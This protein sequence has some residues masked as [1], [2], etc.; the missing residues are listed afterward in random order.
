MRPTFSRCGSPEPFSMLMAWRIRTAAGGVLVT[1]VNERSS[2]TVI[3]TGIVVPMSFAV[4]ALN[5]L[6]N[7]MML[8]PCW[9]S[10]G[11]TGGAGEACP[12][13]AWS[14]MVVRTFFTGSPPR[15]VQ[16]REFERRH[17]V[18]DS[19]LLHLVEAD[20]DRRLAT[21][22][23][24]QDLQAGGVLVDLGDLAA[25]VRQ[26]ARDDL[27]GLAD[28]VLGARALADRD[29]LVQQAVDLGLGERHGLIGGADEAGHAGRALDHAPGVL[30]E[31]H[32]D[33]HVAGHGALLDGDLL[34]VLHPGHGLRRHDHLAH[35]AL[36]PHGAHAV[37]E[38][39]LDLVLVPGIG[40]DDVPAEQCGSSLDDQVDDLLR[41]EVGE[42]E[43]GAGD[44]DKA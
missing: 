36:L 10:A 25:E 40:V 7:S 14:L 23:G 18:S 24:Y 22:D 35:G 5:A 30:V 41:D 2:K 19:K 44:R 1:N 17:H 6:T 20:L 28:R 31:V 27:D 9:P 34:V 11:P 12:P 32:V 4:C 26:R 42:A 38:V 37:L 8:M 16:P 43:V 21:E 3:S 29:L 39:L 13:G 33:Q 15:G